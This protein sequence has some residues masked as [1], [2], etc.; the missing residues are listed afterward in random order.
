MHLGA[1]TPKLTIAQADAMID[2]LTDFLKLVGSCF[3]SIDRDEN[4]KQRDTITSDEDH[5]LMDL[6]N[7]MSR[8]TRAIRE[9]AALRASL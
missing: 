9:T 7:F 5:Q 4:G 2:E 1:N 3:D 8:I 6:M